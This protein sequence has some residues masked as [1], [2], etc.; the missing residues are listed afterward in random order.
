MVEKFIDGT[1]VT[2]EYK[3]VL[4]KMMDDACDAEDEFSLDELEQFAAGQPKVCTGCHKRRAQIDGYCDVCFPSDG[5][6]NR[7]M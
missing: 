3:T 2:E 4:K 7:E 1:P 6:S 5:S